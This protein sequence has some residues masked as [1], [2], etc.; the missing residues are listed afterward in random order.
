LFDT[1]GDANVAQRGRGDNPASGAG[2]GI[3][4]TFAVL[5]DGRIVG[6]ARLPAVAGAG[7]ATAAQRPSRAARG[8]AAAFEEIGRRRGILCEPTAIEAWL[9]V[10]RARGLLVERA[11]VV[12][13]IRGT[14]A[15]RRIVRRETG[16]DGRTVLRA[17]PV[18]PP[19]RYP[20]NCPWH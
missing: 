2:S 20:E 1:E 6:A 8:L 12:D 11:S 16:R 19:N 9:T 10:F 7:A 15:R 14:A 17:A 5:S 3:P 4:G 18:T 13:P